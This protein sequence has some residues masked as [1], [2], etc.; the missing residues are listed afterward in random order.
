MDGCG[1]DAGERR[2]DNAM[3]SVAG[4]TKGCGWDPFANL[5]YYR[6]P[7]RVS[8]VQMLRANGISK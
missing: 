2:D 6:N 1:T 7:Y 8:I 4:I 5:P 3:G